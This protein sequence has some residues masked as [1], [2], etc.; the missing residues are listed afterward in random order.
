MHTAGQVGKGI[1]LG[2]AVTA[3]AFVGAEFLAAASQSPTAYSAAAAIT[4][5]APKAFAVTVAYG[6]LAP[7]GAPDL[8]GPG[9]D[10]GRAARRAAGGMVG[11]G[12]HGPVTII[13]PPAISNA[14]VARLTRAITNRMLA[15]GIPKANIG[16]RGQ[17]GVIPAFVSATTE[18]GNQIPKV[19]I[20]LDRGILGTWVGWGKFNAARLATRVDAVLA[21]EWAEFTNGGNHIQACV[22]A[23]FTNLPILAAARALLMTHPH[24]P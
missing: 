6:L 1:G 12:A 20:W 5:S 18:V 17:G 11:A 23:P 16:T 14:S 2:V 3:G 15:L 9:D 10:V 13:A 24:R 4:T 21:H 7:P 19:G 22:D 8:P